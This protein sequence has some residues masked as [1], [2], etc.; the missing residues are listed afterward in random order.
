MNQVTIQPT[1]KWSFKV[2]NPVKINMSMKQ[3]L[4]LGT[5]AGVGVAGLQVLAMMGISCFG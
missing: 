4:I 1:P 5:L 2:R 3:A